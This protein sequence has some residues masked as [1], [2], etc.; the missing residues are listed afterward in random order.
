M[1]FSHILFSSICLFCVSIVSAQKITGSV[2]LDENKNLKKD[3]GEDGLSGVMVSNGRD[4]AKTDQEGNWALTSNDRPSVFV[5]QPSGY[6]VPTNDSMVPQHYKELAGATNGLAFPIW[7]D[8]SSSDEFE[9]LLFGDTQARGLREVNF[10]MHDVVEEVIGSQAKFGV[11]LGDIVADDPGLFDEIGAG[12]GQIGIP[13]YYVFGNHD[14]NKGA[15]GNEGSDAT[16]RRNFGPPVYA[17]EFGKVSFVSLNS[18]DF[19]KE[20][21]YRAHFSADQIEFLGQ[22]ERHIPKENLL[23]LMMHIPIVACDNREEVFAILEK[24]QHTLTIAGHTHMLA[25]LFVDEKYGWKGDEPHHLFINGTVSGSWWCGINDELGIP[26]TTMNDGAP[27]GYASIAFSD[28]QYKIRYKAARRPADYQMN[29]YLPEEIQSAVLDTTEVLVNFFN[30]SSRSTVEMQLDQEGA[31][32]PL[33]QTIARDP[34]NV[35]MYQLNEM[36]DTKF[37]GQPL[38]E[39]LGWKMDYPSESRHFWKNTLP[40]KLIKGTHTIKIRAKDFYGNTFY[41]HRIFRV[42]R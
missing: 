17:F 13:W 28:N 2:Y 27:N 12:I 22:Y 36:L 37:Q 41:A 39:I 9:G 42:T 8:E 20:G 18:V 11:A 23:V 14:N 38:D 15:K 34:A 7:K 24:R 4:V 40:E 25:N 33:T 10:V 29:I 1:K 19:K 30:G 31:W 32:L 21:G 3:A 26:H 16:F 35:A 6:L 5:I